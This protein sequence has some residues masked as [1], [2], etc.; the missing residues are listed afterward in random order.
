MTD[1]EIA[2]LRFYAYSDKDMF[3]E[4]YDEARAEIRKHL[5]KLHEEEEIV[6]EKMHHKLIKFVKARGYE[7][8]KDINLSLRKYSLYIPLH[9]E[10][11]GNNLH[12][13]FKEAVMVKDGEIKMADE[14]EL[15]TINHRYAYCYEEEDEY[16]RY[17]NHRQQ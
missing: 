12:T 9:S 11:E 8:V 5:D 17:Y 13:P 3:G 14:L 2:K 4:E 1:E 10:N 15:H 6:K 16:D 7:T